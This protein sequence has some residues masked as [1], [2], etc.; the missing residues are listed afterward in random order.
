MTPKILTYLQ[1][2]EAEK[3]I[4]ILLACETGSRAWGFPSP[5]SDF[6]VRMIYVHKTNWYLSVNE[7]RDTLE[8]M[9]EN[10]ELDITGW[11]LKKAL[12]LM[13]K[14]NPALL[15]RI[16]SPIVYRADEEFVQDMQE[17]AWSHYSR[18]TAIHHY[19]S[20][21]KKIADEF[22]DRNEYKLKKLFYAL[23]TATVC[24]WISERTEIPPIE[25][26]R[27]YNGLDLAP[28]LVRRIDEL[29]QLKKTK[30][31][32][33]L[34]PNEP[35]IL[36]FIQSCLEE[37]ANIKHTLSAGRRSVAELNAVLRK[38]IHKYDP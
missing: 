33:Y 26:P 3:D 23:R 7:A 19:Y 6:D 13:G 35:L 8:R 31:E 16:Q 36:D 1:K 32:S 38:Y 2:L 28:N 34:H 29:I 5:D 11:E 9:F 15:E 4:H 10:R 12:T 18:I 25:F 22:S 37:T 21:A 24:K 14:S 30:P 20:M 27:I 17:I